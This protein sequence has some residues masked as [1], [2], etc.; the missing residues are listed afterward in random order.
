MLKK[1]KNRRPSIA[2]TALRLFH[3]VAHLQHEAVHFGVF[4]LQ[5]RLKFADTQSNEPVDE[6]G[7]RQASESL[8]LHGLR[9][10]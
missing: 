8:P 1:G 6:F 10:P 7:H 4:I 2:G 3:H 9:T 5:F